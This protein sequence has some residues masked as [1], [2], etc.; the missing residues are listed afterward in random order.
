M[1]GITTNPV[2]VSTIIAANPTVIT[3]TTPFPKTVNP[4]IIFSGI[5]QSPNAN[6]ADTIIIGTK[7]FT[8]ITISKPASNPPTKQPNGIVIIPAKIPF[9]KN[10]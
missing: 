10:L 9:A 5:F 1:P 2:N 6:N 3:I 4:L 7:F 8:I